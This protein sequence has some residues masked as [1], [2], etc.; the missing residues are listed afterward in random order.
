MIIDSMFG[1]IRAGTFAGNFEIVLV[2]ALFSLAF[3]SATKLFLILPRLELIVASYFDPTLSVQSIKIWFRKQPKKPPPSN[4]SSSGSTS[5]AAESEHEHE[6]VRRRVAGEEAAD[7]E[8]R[9]AEEAAAEREC[10]LQRA[11]EK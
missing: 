2:V 11:A 7:H 3:S 6:R 10:V 8:R 4:D 5:A 1:M 9:A